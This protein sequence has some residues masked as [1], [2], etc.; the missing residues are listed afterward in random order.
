MSKIKSFPADLLLQV[1]LFVTSLFT[2][3]RLSL[4]L[5]NQIKF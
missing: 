1:A 2:L 4:N 3:T 5:A